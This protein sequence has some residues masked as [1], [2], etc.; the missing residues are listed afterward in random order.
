MDGRYLSIS[1]N[2]MSVVFAGIV[3]SEVCICDIETIHG[4]TGIE[5]NNFVH[6]IICI[7]NHNID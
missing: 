1:P 2:F 5:L 6:A 3:I 4:Q 7:G